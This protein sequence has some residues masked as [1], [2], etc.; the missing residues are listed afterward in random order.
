MERVYYTLTAS[1]VGELM[2]SGTGDELRM[3]SF[4]MGSRSR[5]PADEWVEDAAPF[6]EALRQLNAYFGGELKDF[7]LRL[8]P[9]GTDFQ[10]QVWRQLCGIPYGTTTSYGALAK[11][12]GNPA[13]SRAVGLA[14]GANPIAIIVPCHRVIGSTGK[15]TGFGGGLDIKQRL[16]DLERGARL[17]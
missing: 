9:Q 13:A 15:L 5:G 1:P 3:L 4:R 16:L 17:L 6:R 14:N 10:R 12:L 8:A 7:D 2:L 11:R